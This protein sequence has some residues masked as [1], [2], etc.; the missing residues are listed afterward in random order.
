MTT[1]R[2]Q[3]SG[4]R[5]VENIK[6]LSLPITHNAATH[7]L[8]Q[9]SSIQKL[10]P[11]NSTSFDKDYMMA[12]EENCGVLHVYESGEGADLEDDDELSPARLASRVTNVNSNVQAF[13][14]GR[15]I[16]GTGFSDLGVVNVEGSLHDTVGG[17]DADGSLKI[18]SQTCTKLLKSYLKNI[19]NLHPI[20][21]E[22]QLRKMITQYAETYG[23]AECSAIQSCSRM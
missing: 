19:H 8:L 16:W 9:W 17:L 6:T 14:T 10:F 22:D 7:K 4:L 3:A 5:N 18:D 1:S 11:Q 15:N 23:K 12:L 20:F 13:F 2:L 21:N